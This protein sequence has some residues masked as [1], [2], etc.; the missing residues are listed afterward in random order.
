MSSVHPR[1]LALILAA[2]KHWS[3][4]LKRLLQLWRYL[5]QLLRVWNFVARLR[6]PR[7]G[8]GSCGGENQVAGIEDIPVQGASSYS[9]HRPVFDSSLVGTRCTEVVRLGFSVPRPEA[10]TIC[11]SRRPLSALDLHLDVPGHAHFLQPG[12][13]PSRPQSLVLPGRPPAARS[14]LLRPYSHS[15]GSGSNISVS[16]RSTGSPARRGRHFEVAHPRPDAIPNSRAAARGITRV[17]SRAPS[18][19]TSASRRSRA[20]SRTPARSVIELPIPLPL[21]AS[22]PTKSTTPSLRTMS[23][24]EAPTPE[25]IIATPPIRQELYPVTEIPRYDSYATISPARGDWVLTPVTTDFPIDNVPAGW[26]AVTHPE[27]RLYF[28]DDRR[29]IFT[30]NDVR[31]PGIAA[32]LDT[33]AR[34]L[35]EMILE[36][37]L[38]LPANHEL[39]LFLE[40]RKSAPGVFNWCYYFVDHSTR[41]LF[42]IH[43]CDPVETLDIRE[44]IALKAPYDIRHEIQSKYWMHIEMYPHQRHITPDVYT[45]LTGMLTFASMDST[46]SMTSTVAYRGDDVHRMITLVKIAKSV[47]GTD[48]ATAVIGRLMC[49]WTHYRF[50][51]F[52]GQ[53]HARLNRDQSVYHGVKKRRTLLI[54][55]FAP[56]FWNAPHVHLRSLEKIYIDE[57]ITIIPWGGF[58]S[59]LQNEWQEFVLYATV[60]LNANVAFLAIP[61][62]DTGS[63][64]HVTPARISSF[65][66]I[67]T[68]VGSILLGLLLIRQHRVKSK[69]TA[70]EAHRFLRSRKHKGLGLE[71][72]A[73]I[74][75]LPYALLMW[76]MITFLLAFSFECFSVQTHSSLFLTGAGWV[77]IGLLVCWTIITGWESG[78]T[79]RWAVYKERFRMFFSK[80]D[81]DEDDGASE[82]EGG[83]AAPSEKRSSASDKRQWWSRVR[84][85][86][87]HS[88]D[89]A[90]LNDTPLPAVRSRPPSMHV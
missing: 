65:L 70:E 78:E 63:L 90:R 54:R 27:G 66:S 13:L 38:E 25:I 53:T 56:F 71:T 14:E 22:A 75:S 44:V 77:I 40:P 68:S 50:F 24:S 9:P 76:G 29:R 2:C 89:F 26:K 46:T 49:T 81:E 67:V 47:D 6:R 5:K 18:R 30:D 69:D 61:S 3:S 43:E 60:L 86:L 84:R 42:W 83:S 41:T 35:D 20:A 7:G 33:F 11:E 64:D 23:V 15:T 37:S 10:V 34:Q 48:Y 88:L 36:Q 4:P 19:A 31:E 52:Y 87:R 80:D 62:V 1:S 72:L 79:S 45:E 58:I 74:Y 57:V 16:I 51:N 55:F 17:A 59:K 21:P 12:D 8:G 39:V 82:K 85:S 28:Y 32:M 73:I